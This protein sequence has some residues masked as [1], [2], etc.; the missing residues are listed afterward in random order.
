MCLSEAEALIE[1]LERFTK[2]N[3]TFSNIKKVKIS[4]QVKIGKK[5]SPEP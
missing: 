1:F 5:S 3:I 2:F 4:K